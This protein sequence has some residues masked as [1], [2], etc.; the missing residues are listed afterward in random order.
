MTTINCTGRDGITR[1]FDYV[2]SLDLNGE[3]WTFRVTP[4]PPLPSADFFDVTVRE[5]TAGIVQV[6]QINHYNVP[7]L[8]AKGIPEALLPIVKASLNVS[9]TSSPTKGNSG[10]VYRTPAATKMWKRLESMGL[11]SYDPNADIYSLT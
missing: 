5:L 7:E 6:V 2:S 11:A 10:N 3:E 9:V 8:M 4:I 1:V